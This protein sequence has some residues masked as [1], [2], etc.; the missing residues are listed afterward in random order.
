MRPSQIGRY[1]TPPAALPGTFEAMAASRGRLWI[2]LVLLLAVMVAVA[3]YVVTAP[4]PGDCPDPINGPD[5][6]RADCDLP[7]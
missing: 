2:L 6:G 5:S 1:G 3:V 4:E 7:P